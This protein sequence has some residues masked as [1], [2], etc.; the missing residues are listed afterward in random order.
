M[1]GAALRTCA[2]RSRSRTL[3]ATYSASVTLLPA[4]FFASHAACNSCRD[5]DGRPLGSFS[6][7][8]RRRCTSAL[9]ALRLPPGTTGRR[10]RPRPRA[11]AT[12]PPPAP[13]AS[14]STRGRRSAAS[15]TLSTTRCNS[16][17]VMASSP[18]HR[19]SLLA[20]PLT[21]WPVGRRRDVRTLSRRLR[22]A[23]NRPCTWRTVSCGL[24]SPRV[25][26]LPS[27]R[28]PM[29]EVGS[30]LTSSSSPAWD[31]TSPSSTSP[32]S[33]SS[34]ASESEPSSYTV[35][36]GAVAPGPLQAHHT[37]ASGFT[38]CPHACPLV[39]PHAS[40]LPLLEELPLSS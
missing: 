34:P 18:C 37:H 36:S 8:S 24:R 35:R 16:F 30:K 9:R 6:P 20:K 7:H 22:W 25:R 10:G 17:P 13:S 38:H 1:P 32:S 14:P 31:W 4:G 23:R 40:P 26:S 29:A 5:W 27:R 39:V 28:T 21:T 11:G 15:L 19:C 2:A 33:V 12:S 3:R